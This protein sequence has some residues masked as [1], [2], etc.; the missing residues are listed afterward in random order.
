MD[1]SEKGDPMVLYE[2]VEKKYRGSGTDHIPSN[3]LSVIP[4]KTPSCCINPTRRVKNSLLPQK[5]T[6]L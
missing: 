5:E 6:T 4:G 3:G 1:N 2:S